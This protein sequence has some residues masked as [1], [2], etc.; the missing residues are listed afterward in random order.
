MGADVLLPLKWLLTPMARN[1][2][3]AQAPWIRWI[4]LGHQLSSLSL[5]LSLE[6]RVSVKCL[7]N[8]DAVSVS[9]G[10]LESVQALASVLVRVPV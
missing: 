7:A 4:L 5:F 2:L 9:R 1:R 8:E 6:L 10:P 3:G